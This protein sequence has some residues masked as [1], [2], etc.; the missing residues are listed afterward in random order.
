M[1]LCQQGHL[2]VPL[3]LCRSENPLTNDFDKEMRITLLKGA[4]EAKEERENINQKKRSQ[5]RDLD[6][7]LAHQKDCFNPSIH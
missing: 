1:H 3:S 4:E 5:H 2:V 6:R 7:S